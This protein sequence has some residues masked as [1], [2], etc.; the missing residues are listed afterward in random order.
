MGKRE[1][2]MDTYNPD[3]KITTGRISRMKGLANNPKGDMTALCALNLLNPGG[4]FASLKKTNIKNYKWKILKKKYRKNPNTIIPIHA[5]IPNA[6][7]NAFSSSLCFI[8][9]P[10]TP[11]PTTIDSSNIEKN[12]P[13]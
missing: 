9:A 13:V 2:V 5:I 1:K 6:I 3:S 8:T 12:V 10:A 11:S 4:L 7:I